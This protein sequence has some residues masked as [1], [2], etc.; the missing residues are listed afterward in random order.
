MLK[1]RPL[2]IH[3]PPPPTGGYG[4]PFHRLCQCNTFYPE[5]RKM[6]LRIF[7]MRILIIFLNLV[8]LAVSIDD[9]QGPL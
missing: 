1:M 9:T 4:G 7:L 2:S 5:N 6:S 3:E 8:V